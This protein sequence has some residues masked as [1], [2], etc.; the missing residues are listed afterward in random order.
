LQPS[1]SKPPLLERLKKSVLVADGA[2][3][4]MVT[5]LAAGDVE[6]I[7]E[8][9]LTNPDLIAD[10]HRQYVRA[11]ANIIE[12]NTFGANRIALGRFRR[13]DETI[14]CIRESVRIAAAEAAPD[15][16]VAGSIGPLRAPAGGET[17]DI[18]DA[19]YAAALAEQVGALIDG[20]VDLLIFE[21]YSD[22]DE[23][24]E[25]VRTARSLC[26]LPVI[27]SLTAS[28][29][30]TT[31]AG[32]N[33]ERSGQRLIDAGADILGLNCGYGIRAIEGAVDSLAGLGAPLSVMPNAGFPERTGGRLRYGASEEYFAQAAVTFAAK[34]A[35]IIG[36]CCGTTPAHIEAIVRTLREKR[37]VVRQRRRPVPGEAAEEAGF[38]TG[39][40]LDSFAAIRLPIICEIDPPATMAVEKNI[41]AINAVVGAGANAISLADNPLATVKIENLA[42]A[43]L[44]KKETNAGIVLHVTGR[45]RNLLGLQSFMLGAQL[46]GIEALLCVT[47]DPSTMHGGPTN[48]FDVN[49]I[50]LLKMA[51]GLNRGKNLLGRDIG[52][53][54]SFSLGAAVNPNVSD[55]APQLRHLRNKV[56]AGA[57]FAMTQPLYEAE[58][59]RAFIEAVRGLGLKIFIGHMPVLSARTAE[60][61]HHEV[62]GISIPEPLR[63]ALGS[64]DDAAYQRQAGLDHS[65]KFIAEVAPVVD[66][67]YL[68]APHT[69]PREIEG[70]VA[71]A[72]K[73]V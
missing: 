4:T 13:Q 2:L 5:A 37:I 3:G 57:R 55:I 45:D 34:G 42:F 33:L 52:V 54:A 44:V 22:A 36:G 56:A 23:L 24:V 47:G 65:Q 12:T 8:L 29:T 48:V 16:Y 59:V 38:K 31:A 1:F 17:G 21:T 25:S 46:A 40:L 51:A 63:A 70:L 61:L 69:R 50:G 49:S 39:K 58:K 67:L 60:Y 62:P 14:S 30:G 28:R 32:Q 64:R 7:E 68:I 72:R 41:D 11:G 66:G 43:C 20:G 35:R 9:S 15:V 6:C 73:S 27:A 53:H 71:F 19:D 26:R 10:I 18:S